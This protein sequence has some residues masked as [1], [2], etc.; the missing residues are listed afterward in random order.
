MMRSKSMH[1]IDPAKWRLPQKKSAVRPLGGSCVGAT[2]ALDLGVGTVFAVD[3]GT[4]GAFGL[5]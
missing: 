4:S 3:D 1:N 5:S 2:S